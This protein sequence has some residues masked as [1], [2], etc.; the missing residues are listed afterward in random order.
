MPEKSIGP[1]VVPEKAIDWAKW[2]AVA[3]GLVIAFAGGVATTSWNLGRIESSLAKALEGNAEQ[4]AQIQS[5]ADAL[6]REAEVR[7]EADAAHD[8]EPAHREAQMLHRSVEVHLQD[9][10]RHQTQETKRRNHIEWNE[11]LRRQVDLI[12]QRLDALE[13][14]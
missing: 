4:K 14:K 10:G 2:S 12:R 7:R 13:K 3:V 11:E 8:K 6:Q 5:I 1:F 9:T